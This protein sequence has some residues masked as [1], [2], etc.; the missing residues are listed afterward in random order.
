M[1]VSRPPTKAKAAVA[2]VVNFVVVVVV[3]VVMTPVQEVSTT[4]DVTCVACTSTQFGSVTTVPI[5]VSSPAPSVCVKST[6][7]AVEDE[8][9]RPWSCAVSSAPRAT[10]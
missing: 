8:L 1:A 2:A 9:V 3:V 6:S 4:I 7:A 10:G 5:T